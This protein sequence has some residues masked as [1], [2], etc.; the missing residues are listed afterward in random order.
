MADLKIHSVRQS[1]TT[2]SFPQTLETVNHGLDHEITNSSRH[3]SLAR[4][5]Q[6]RLPARLM[7]RL[8]MLCEER[9]TIQ[10]RAR[11]LRQMIDL[12]RTMRGSTALRKILILCYSTTQRS[13][14]ATLAIALRLGA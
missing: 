8:A 14:S 4:A 10:T 12:S 11:A 13:E 7:N 5:P 2:S 6:R 1:E 9:L 3:I